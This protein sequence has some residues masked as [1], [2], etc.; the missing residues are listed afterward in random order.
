MSHLENSNTGFVISS[1]T[2]SITSQGTI[3]QGLSTV[4]A[5]TTT[6]Y[7]SGT[8]Y[9]GGTITIAPPIWPTTSPYTNTLPWST[10]TVYINPLSKLY[11]EINFEIDKKDLLKN[12]ISGIKNN[13][14]LFNCK[15]EGNRIQPYEFIMKLIEDHKKFSVKVKV[16]DILTICYKNLQFTKIENNLSFNGD[17]DFSVL[18]V[19]FKYEKILYENHKLSEKELRTEKLKKLYDKEN[20]QLSEE[21]TN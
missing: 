10:D 14:F 6:V 9:P 17:C 21:T 18:K 5:G 16:S 19:K 12:S 20:L 3:Y 11:Y 7:P 2:D 13:K 15:F 1:N 4:L 8:I